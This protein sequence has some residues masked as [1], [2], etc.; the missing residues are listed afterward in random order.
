MW[1]GLQ[2]EFN[3]EWSSTERIWERKVELS[4]SLRVKKYSGGYWCKAKNAATPDN[5]G[6]HLSHNMCCKYPPLMFLPQ[7]KAFNLNIS[8]VVSRMCVKQY[9]APACAKW[10]SWLTSERRRSA[11]TLSVQTHSSS[12]DSFTLCCSTAASRLHMHLTHR[13]LCICVCS[14]GCN[15][16]KYR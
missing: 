14:E 16:A 8:T 6:V 3:G 7:I 1:G 13:Y 2:Y 15:W 12:P 10:R 9:K 11:E 4:Y 5:P